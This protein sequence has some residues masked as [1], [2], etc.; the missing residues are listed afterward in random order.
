M[1]GE[2]AERGRT[3]EM[4]STNSSRIQ[5]ENQQC[6]KALKPY[7]EKTGRLE[8]ARSC[9]ILTSSPWGCPRQWRWWRKAAQQHQGPTWDLQAV[10]S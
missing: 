1:R 6:E 4:G 9:Q 8:G 7:G 5:E 3:A 2:I 10:F